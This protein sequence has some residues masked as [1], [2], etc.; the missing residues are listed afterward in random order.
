MLYI[1]MKLMNLF[2]EARKLERHTQI[3]NED[4][5]SVCFIM[6]LFFFGFECAIEIHRYDAYLWF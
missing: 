5:D 6:L 3:L 4:Y 1:A 2:E